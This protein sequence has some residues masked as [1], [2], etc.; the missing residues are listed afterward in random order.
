MTAANR[1]LPEK[2]VAIDEALAEIP[3][4]FGGALALAYYAEPR[5]T[6]DIDINV[7]IPA[8][9][10]RRLAVFDR[11][12]DWSTSMQSAKL[13]HK[14]TA[15]RSSAGCSASWATTTHASIAS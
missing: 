11:A 14:S 2:I 7:F 15:P 12:K 4:A 13:A 10:A 9:E 3:H 8:T 1:S 6:V 5:A